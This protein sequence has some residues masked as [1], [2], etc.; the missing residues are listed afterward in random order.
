MPHV[1]KMLDSL[2]FVTLQWATIL[3]LDALCMCK[4]VDTTHKN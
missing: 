3:I 4:N 2:H 1:M